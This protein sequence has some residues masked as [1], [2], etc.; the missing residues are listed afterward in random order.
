[1]EPPLL[2]ALLLLAAPCWSSATAAQGL[3]TLNELVYNN[4][5]T[6]ATNRSLLDVLSERVSVR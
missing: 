5:H 2:G 1:M 4:G 3:P 6:N